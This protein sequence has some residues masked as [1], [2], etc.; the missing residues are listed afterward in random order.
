MSFS[1]NI[2]RTAKTVTGWCC[3]TVFLSD[4]KVDQGN[5]LIYDSSFPF[6]GGFSVAVREDKS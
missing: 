4:K 6:F 5:Y 2:N 1:H 3:G